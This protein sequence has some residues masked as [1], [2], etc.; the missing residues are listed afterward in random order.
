VRY[1]LTGPFKEAVSEATEAVRLN[2]K[3]AKAHANLAIGFIG[4]NKFDEG[5]E[6]LQTAMSRKMETDSMHLHLFHLAFVSGD[7]A[8]MKEQI[9]WASSKPPGYLANVWQAHAAEFYGRFAEA[10][11]F[12]DKAVDWAQHNNRDAAAQ[13]IS[14]QAIRAATFRDC[15]KVS[16]LTSRALSFSRDLS[17]L[18]HS[19]NALAACGQAAAAQSLVDEMQKRFPQDTLLNSVSIPLI[20]AQIALARGNGAQAIEFLQSADN[21]KV[22]GDYW[23]QYV[24][25][26]AY[27]K[28]G[29]GAQA[30]TEFKNILDHRGWYPL[31]PVYA[32]AQLGYA[33]ASAQSGDTAKARQAYQDFFELWK[34]A[35]ATVPFV[36]EARQEYDKLK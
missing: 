8:G 4:L 18:H 34:N 30:A 20:R 35:D 22:Y 10:N 26:Q 13:L 14:Q 23:P 15:G 3:E 27:A 28:Q 7:A 29:D 12:T 32:L 2:P 17:N 33:R 24:R 25:A 36:A 11:Q 31:S 9:D 6:V 16:A 21:Y 5:K 1:T 19:A